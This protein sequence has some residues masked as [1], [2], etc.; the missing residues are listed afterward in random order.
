MKI[1]VSAWSAVD[2][3]ISN[4]RCNLIDF[5]DFCLENGVDSVELLNRFWNDDDT[6]EKIKAYLDQNNMK[7][8]SYSVGGDFVGDEKYYN[9]SINQIKEAVDMAIFLNTDRVRIFSG[10]K[11]EN[12]S[13]EEGFKLVIKGLKDC[14][15]YAK[16]KNVVLCM[17][18]HGFYSGTSDLMK[19]IFDAVG[20][21]AL[22]GNPDTGNFLISEEN[23]ASAFRNLDGYVGFVHFKDFKSSD[24]QAKYHS[25]SGIQYDGCVF[26]EGDVHMAEIIDILKAQGYNGFISIEYE[27][28]DADCFDSIKKCIEYTKSII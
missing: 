5:I 3:L 27:G 19:E 14:A 18:N 6:P 15:Q 10:V 21:D 25:Y 13:Y 26:G 7:V 20:S 23:P 2:A 22:T 12:I 16:S 4:K 28:D 17:E 11:K 9:D 24:K 1:S 8:S